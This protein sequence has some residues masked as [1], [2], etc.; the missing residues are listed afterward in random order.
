M[1]GACL[2]LVYYATM[3]CSDNNYKP[4]LY[5][6]SCEISFKKSYSNHKKSFNV[7]LYIIK[8]ETKLSTEYWS[9]KMKQLNPVISCKLKGIYK[10][11]NPTS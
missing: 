5:K 8:H 4:K 3:N 1:N 9:L 10:S 6:E 2:S 11:Y 7:P